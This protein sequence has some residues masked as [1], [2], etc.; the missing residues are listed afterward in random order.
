MIPHR[1]RSPRATV[2]AASLAISLGCTSEPPPSPPPPPPPPPTVGLTIAGG[3]SQKS[4]ADAEL[5]VLLRVTATRGGALARGQ[6]VQWEVVSG[7]ATIVTQTPTDAQGIAT[8]RIRLTAAGPVSIRAQ[9][10][11]AR[12]VFSLTSVTPSSTPVLVGEVSIPPQYG[13]H[14][15]FV[16]DG[17]AFVSAWNTGVIIYD[18]GNGQKGGS[19]SNPVE[20]G[21]LVTS[22]NSVPGG[23]AVH[24][25][26][27]FHNPV[28]GEKKYLFIGQEG[29][30]TLFSTSSGDLHVVDVSNL[31]APREVASLRIPGAGVHNFW[32]DE[33]KQLLYAAFYNEGVVAVDVSGI[34]SGDLTSRI[35]ARAQPGGAGNTFA[36]GVMLAGGALWVSDVVSGFWKLD[37]T[38]LV[39]LGGGNNVSERWGADLWVQNQYAYTG[40]WGGNARNGSGFGDAVKIWQLAGG[41]PVLVDSIRIADIRTVS[42]LAVSDDGKWLVVTAEKLTKQGLYVYDLANPAKPVLVGSAVV[43]TGLHTGEVARIGGRLFVFAAKNPASPSLQVY[44][45]TR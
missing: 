5:P 42:D 2:L 10:D 1:V 41:G 33:A 19:P 24:N 31:A 32:M 45:I 13:I 27:W 30:A 18:V 43:A 7:G 22:D 14:D 44:D 29:P 11:T 9:L 4:V 6:G 12:A 26:W 23:P 40:T 36:W 35:K 3:N 16:R 34:L 37:P 15:T 25:A 39:T 8:A 20:I 17:I 38:T 28:T 21:R